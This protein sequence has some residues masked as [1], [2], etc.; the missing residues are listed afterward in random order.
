MG[1]ARSEGSGEST[2]LPCGEVHDSLW[3]TYAS[4]VAASEN[5][6]NEEVMKSHGREEGE[7]ATLEAVHSVELVEPAEFLKA[8][9]PNRG[10]AGAAV[11]HRGVAAIQK[12]S[13]M[14]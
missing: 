4:F 6:N 14:V 8:V 1:E 7:Q 5:K 10:F 12:K 11:Y 3:S 2:G 13:K 9:K